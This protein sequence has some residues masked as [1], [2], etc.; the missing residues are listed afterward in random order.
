MQI[1][2]AQILNNTSSTVFWSL[3]TLIVVGCITMMILA[4]ALYKYGSDIRKLND[5][6]TIAKLAMLAHSMESATHSYG[7]TLVVVE[8]FGNKIETF[9]QILDDSEQR[10]STLSSKLNA[11]QSLLEDNQRPPLEPSVT[12]PQMPTGTL[13]D[14]EDRKN[15]EIIRS[16]WTDIRDEIERT[17]EMMDG[18]VR[19][20][21]S[22]APRYKYDK[23]INF[24]EQDKVLGSKA[25][26]AAKNMDGV[27]MQIRPRNAPISLTQVKQF[28]EWKRLVL[29]ELK[30]FKRNKKNG[31][32]KR[33]S[34]TVGGIPPQQKL[35]TQNGQDDKSP[36]EDTNPSELTA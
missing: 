32:S 5:Y 30:K 36:S 26:L 9:G 15:W 11:L 4:H 25:A 13:N 6:E 33:T 29:S 17:I 35:D 14:P 7:K 3:S 27:F 8:G 20:K 21:Y 2:P 1:D 23:I 24:L 10:I 22:E 16:E 34:P 31:A 12:L 18:R 19:R 28:E